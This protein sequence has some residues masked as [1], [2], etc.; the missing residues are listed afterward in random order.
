MKKQPNAHLKAL[1]LAHEVTTNYSRDD[2]CREL[3]CKVESVADAFEFEAQH[4]EL[5]DDGEAWDEL[6]VLATNLAGA[7]RSG[8]PCDRLDAAHELIEALE[9]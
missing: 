3:S 5:E 8:S 1:D 9:I 7:C 4:A 6:C 2:L